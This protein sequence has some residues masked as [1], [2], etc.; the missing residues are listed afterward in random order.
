MSV[1]KTR[2]GSLIILTFHAR[3][4]ANPLNPITG[5]EI[6][7]PYRLLVP[8]IS[9]YSKYFFGTSRSH[10]T[11]DYEAKN[12]NNVQSILT[13]KNMIFVL[14]FLDPLRDCWQPTAVTKL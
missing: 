10:M 1:K 12:N 3:T 9:I 13:S 2:T 7:R 14:C 4:R 5:H 6:L 11:A 8:P